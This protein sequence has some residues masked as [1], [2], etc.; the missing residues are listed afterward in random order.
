MVSKYYEK[1]DLKGACDAVL[2][3]SYAR[4]TKDDDSVI[5][6]ITL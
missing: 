1:G 5:D 3:E 6:D 4:W 2:E